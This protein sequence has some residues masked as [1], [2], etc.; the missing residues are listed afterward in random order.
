MTKKIRYMLVSAA[1]FLALSA[2]GRKGGAIDSGQ[3]A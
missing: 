2:C 3:P 1:L